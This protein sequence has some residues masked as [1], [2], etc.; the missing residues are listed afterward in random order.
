MKKLTLLFICIANIVFSQVKPNNDLWKMNLKGKVKSVREIQYIESQNGYVLQNPSKFTTTKTTFNKMGDVIK[1]K[2]N[3]ENGKKYKTKIKNSYYKRSQDENAN[4]TKTITKSNLGDK[5]INHYRYDSKSRLLLAY[6]NTNK[7]RVPVL[8]DSKDYYE[9]ELKEN[10]YTKKISNRMGVLLSKEYFTCDEKGNILKKEFYNKDGFKE[11]IETFKYD[12]NN[13]VIERNYS[14]ITGNVGD[15]PTYLDEKIKTYKYILDKHNNWI[16]K[17]E[18]IDGKLSN[19]T[20]R[21][22]KYY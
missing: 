19:T 16:S 4:K 10:N 13:N 12:E 1:V 3:F 20:T 22:I 5:V 17:T 7:G 2:I 11:N 14:A 6:N 21:E 9:Y 8:H 15:K 18:Y